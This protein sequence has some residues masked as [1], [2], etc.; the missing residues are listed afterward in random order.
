MWVQLF[1]LILGENLNSETYTYIIYVNECV[2]NILCKNQGNDFLM[3]P[4]FSKSGK[5]GFCISNADPFSN[6]VF[7]L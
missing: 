2:Y 6:N 5:G 3:N 7:L 4:P 1:G